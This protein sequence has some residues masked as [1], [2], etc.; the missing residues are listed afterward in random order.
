MVSGLNYGFVV[1]CRFNVFVRVLFAVD[2]CFTVYWLYW[3]S[4]FGLVIDY[5]VSLELIL[6]FCFVVLVD[7]LG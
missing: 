5:F 3:L 7:S 1:G 6:L 2:V 4:M